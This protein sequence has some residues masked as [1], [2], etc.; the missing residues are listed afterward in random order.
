MTEARHKRIMVLGIFGTE[1]ADSDWVM[2]IFFV[3]TPFAIQM[4]LIYVSLCMFC[5]TILKGLA[6]QRGPCP[7]GSHASFAAFQLCD[8]G[9]F[10]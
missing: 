10:I 2:G 4:C 9:T 6:K 3:L 5:F 7:L 1:G 8:F